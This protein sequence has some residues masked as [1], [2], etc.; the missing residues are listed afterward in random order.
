MRK[1]LALCLL[2]GLIWALPRDKA[3]IDNGQSSNAPHRVIPAFD[4]AYVL[5]D[6]SGN[7]YSAWTQ[8][9]ECLAFNSA[10]NGL[11]F[12]NRGFSP[13]GVL[14][15]HQTDGQFS[16]WVDDYAVYSQ[17]NN[18][19]RYPTSIASDDGSYQYGPHISFPTLDASGAAWGFL[20]GQAEDG[21]WY[22]SFWGSPVDIGP[23]NL[24]THKCNGKQLPDMNILFIGVDTGNNIYYRTYSPD[25]G[26]S[27]ATGMVAT[28][29]YYWG[30]D[31]NGGIAYV[32]YYDD[33]LNV[34]YKTT[35]DGVTWSS[36][37][38]YNLVWPNPYPSNLIFW[39]Q[40][41]VTDAGDPILIFDN[42]DNDDYNS[43]PY[44]WV[45]K[46]YVSLGSGQNCVEMS[47]GLTEN[48]YPTVASSGNYI[49]AL[50]HSPVTSD[51]DSL[52]FWNL[53]Y[54]FSDDGGSSWNG[55]LNATSSVP[56]RHGLA[57]LSKRLDATNGNF[58][59]FFGVNLVVDH[60]PIYHTYLDPEGLDPHVWY[61]GWQELG[62]AEQN[63][64]IPSKIALTIANP[65]SARGSIQYALTNSGQVSIKVFDSSGR[66]VR[67][68]ADGYEEAGVHT[69]N[70][71]TSDLASGTYFVILDTPAGNASGSMV[72]IH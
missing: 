51:I 12:L 14:N 70:I 24:A 46:V 67:T 3:F 50:W 69:I 4:G 22:S 7:A 72:V 1:I 57:Q 15:V 23:G 68:I 18:A 19:A 45:G 71:N 52:T 30:F 40:A 60:D 10:V 8:M 35:T 66:I 55:P 58:F 44:P 17:E 29:M 41:C 64:E 16:F 33:Y 39:T 38:S 48:F 37:Q 43:N 20:N 61:V 63:T 27:V 31:I 53:F 26:T 65:V 47:T 62:V 34:Y 59:Y 36:E 11:E 5:V 2:V 32:F 54:T 21:F 9:Q 28:A 13:T 49:V 56:T 25:M 42:L 6:S